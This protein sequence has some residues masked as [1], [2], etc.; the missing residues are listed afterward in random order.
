MQ[1]PEGEPGEKSIEEIK[2]ISTSDFSRAINECGGLSTTANQDLCYLEISSAANNKDSCQHI[3]SNTQKDQ[4]YM[5]WALNN[6]D[7]SI[8]EELN[9]ANLKDSCELLRG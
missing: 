2:D 6:N 1:E 9:N 3:I 4:C 8:C 7:Y 5:N